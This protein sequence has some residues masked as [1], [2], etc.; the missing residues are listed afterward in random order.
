[1]TPADPSRAA[2]AAEL[3]ALSALAAPIII[4]Q[5]GMNLMGAV[6]TMVAGRLGDQALAALA[7]GNVVYF[8][9]LV[10]GAGTLMALDSQVS[11]AFGAGRLGRAREWHVQGVFLALLITPVLIAAMSVAPAILLGLGYPPDMVAIAADYLGPLRWGV[12]P[13]LLFACYRSFLSAVGRTRP[14][15]VSAA[16]ANLAN[17]GLDLWLSRGGLG[18]EPLG[19]LGISWSTAACRLVL[20]APLAIL[21]HGAPSMRHFPTPRWRPIAS[22]LRELLRIGLPVGLQFGA[23]VGTFGLAALLMGALGAVPLAAHQVS[24][25]F[26]SMVFM[27]PLGLGAAAAVRAG[28]AVGRRDGPGVRRVGQVAIGC[29]VLYAFAA[30]AVLLLFPRPIAVAFGLDGEALLLALDL[31][32]IA[33]F[34][35]VADCIQIVTVGILRGLADTRAAFLLVLAGHVALSIPLGVLGGPGW[36]QEPRA[37]WVALTLGLTAN[38]VTLVRRFWRRSGELRDELGTPPPPLGVV[39]EQPA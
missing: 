34:F 12:L 38:A 4:A 29:S 36:L 27:V 35:Q 30:A 39:Q 23:E 19:V 31:F 21:V 18:I 37:V 22:D 28:Q 6:D 10:T 24:L 11:E 7:L 26:A 20:L 13:A 8:G 32:A 25:T 14:L 16:L 5:V 33:A 3:R 17:L 9:L 2:L 15:L 1:M